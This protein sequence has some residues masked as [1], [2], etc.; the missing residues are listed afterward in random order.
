MDPALLLFAFIAGAAAFFAPCCVAMLP[1]YIGYAI[2]PPQRDEKS[3]SPSNDFIDPNRPAPRNRRAAN[4]VA[5]FGVIPVILG[6]VPLV[7]YGLRTVSTTAASWVLP[8]QDASLGLVLLGAAV[9]TG[10]LAWAGKGQAAARGALFGTLATLGL[11]A[12]FVTIGLPV[13]FL[14]RSLAPWI[15]WLS[16]VVGVGLVVL[17]LFF[18][19]GKSFYLRLPGFSGDV[20]TPKGFF[21]FGLGYGVAGLSCTFPVFLAVIG[22]GALSGGFTAALAVFAAYAL[23]KGFLLVGVTML[24]VAGGTGM[25]HRVKELTPYVYRGS[26]VLMI[27]AGAYIA[28]YFGRYA[29]GLGG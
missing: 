27:V 12:V 6:I 2:R 22:A 29:L 21:L 7:L 25:A 18:L 5:L 13:A 11:L 17:G 15:P 14:A 26:A 10:G 23:G 20:S 24:T 1:A 16:V 19:L 3:P 9:V 28:Y 4:A 8:R